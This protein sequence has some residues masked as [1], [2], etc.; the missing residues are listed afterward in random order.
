MHVQ[1]VIYLYREN[2][3]D[4]NAIKEALMRY[5]AVATGI[6]QDSTYLNTRT[7]GY[8]NPYSDYANHAVTID[9]SE[10]FTAP[11]ILFQIS[12]IIADNINIFPS[13][14]HILFIES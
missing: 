10:T 4:N 13:P 1:N 14:K 11:L 7:G 8:Y 3:T 5:G 2:Y 6:L 9:T 12:P